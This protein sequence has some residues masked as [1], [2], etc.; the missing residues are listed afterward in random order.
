MEPGKQ[1]LLTLEDKGLRCQGRDEFCREGNQLRS[2]EGPK[3]DVSRS[4]QDLKNRTPVPF[5]GDAPLT[6][7]E[8][9]APPTP[10][11]HTQV[12]AVQPAESSDLGLSE[13]SHISHGWHALVAQS[14]T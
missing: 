6:V 9:H 5:L 7:Q 10:E 14:H 13:D 1:A 4:P 8:D 11:T 2:L 12:P 3:Q